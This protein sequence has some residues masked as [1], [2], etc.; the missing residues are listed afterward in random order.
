MTY[1][2]PKDWRDK[3]PNADAFYHARIDKLSRP[4]QGNWAQGR[5]PFHEDRSASLSVHMEGRGHWKCFSGCGHGD[6]VSFAMRQSGKPFADTVREL[7]G[8]GH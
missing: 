6:M 7:I 1:R 2:L 3:L 8:A 5:C 4:N